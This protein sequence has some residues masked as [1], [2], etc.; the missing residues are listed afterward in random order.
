[1]EVQHVTYPKLVQLRGCKCLHEDCSLLRL[2]MV[3]FV[4]FLCLLWIALLYKQVSKGE[5]RRRKK[6]KG[7]LGNEKMLYLICVFNIHK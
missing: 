3:N 6:E 7:G 2:V 5:E 4:F 1:M